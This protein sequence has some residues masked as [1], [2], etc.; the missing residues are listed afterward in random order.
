MDE[1]ARIRRLDDEAADNGGLI[2]RASLPAAPHPAPWGWHPAPLHSWP[3]G[4]P[5]CRES[6][7][8][9]RDPSPP[10]QIWERSRL[11]RL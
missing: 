5:P 9:R 4:R 10:S 6:P 3:K 11:A 1:N 2:A 7:R 8:R